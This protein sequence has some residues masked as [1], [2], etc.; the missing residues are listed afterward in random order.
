MGDPLPFAGRDYF[1]MLG[2]LVLGRG[3]DFL[4]TWIATPR[5][6]LEGNPVARWLG[7][8]WGSV[9]NA[10]VCVV[11]A[12]W[13]VTALTIATT[14]VLVAARNFQSAWLMRTWGEENFRAWYVERLQCT[15]PTLYLFCL[16]GQALPV[17]ALGG[18]LIYFSQDFE[19]VWV[20]PLGIG[21]GIIGYALAVVL[22]S[23]VSVWRSRR[24]WR[25]EA[26]VRTPAGGPEELERRL[27]N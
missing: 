4:S 16:F 2:L 5:L 12:L 13:P 11:F 27:S 9:L 21:L 18:V 24:A 15:S 8:R 17:A 3:L 1:L 26:R 20:V 10:G 7:W 23:V 19:G 22:F 14:S 25:L 6:V